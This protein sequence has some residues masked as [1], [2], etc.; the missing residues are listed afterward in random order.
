MIDTPTYQA[1]A[2]AFL[3]PGSW[4]TRKDGC[5]LELLDAL[6]VDERRRAE[7]ALLA[8]LE[9]DDWPVR[10]LGHIRSTAA[11]PALRQLLNGAVGS[12]AGHIATA[13][14]KISGDHSMPPMVIGLSRRHYTEDPKSPDTFVM[15][16]VIFCLADIGTPETSERILELRSSTNYLIEW[17]AGRCGPARGA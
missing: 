13:I 9:G 11:L 16:D 7:Q 5:P 6:D 12:L 1:F 10:A 2:E 17:N 4:S 14:W 8:R 3:T 15:I